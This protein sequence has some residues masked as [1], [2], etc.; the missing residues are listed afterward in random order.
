MQVREVMVPK[1]QMVVIK[2]NSQYQDLVP[3]VAESGHSRFPVMDANNK[4]VVGILL[5]K[6]LLQFGFNK[7]NC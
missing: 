7:D 3:I 6:D 5:A 2:Q 1:G 4:E